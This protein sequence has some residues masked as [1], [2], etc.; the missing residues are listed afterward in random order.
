VAGIAIQRSA[1]RKKQVLAGQGLSTCIGE[2]AVAFYDS[3]FVFDG[4]CRAP[5]SRGIM[6]TT[7][8]VIQP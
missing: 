3:A 7:S 1:D 4:I 5:P 6:P 8:G 2:S